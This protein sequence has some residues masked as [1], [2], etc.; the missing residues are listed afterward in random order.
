MGKS[1]HPPQKT[2][3][4]S[5]MAAQTES[6]FFPD[7]HSHPPTRMP[8]RRMETGKNGTPQARA[9]PTNPPMPRS[10]KPSPPFSFR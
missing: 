7:F 10:R 9:S 6:R 2:P 1:I 5:P 3:Q 4:A 8:E